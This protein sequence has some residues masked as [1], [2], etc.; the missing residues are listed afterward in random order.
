LEAWGSY[1]VIKRGNIRR[2]GTGLESGGKTALEENG[3][4][5]DERGHSK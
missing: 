1:K 4:A 3:E 2:S 5:F